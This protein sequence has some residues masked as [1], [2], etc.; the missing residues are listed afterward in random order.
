MQLAVVARGSGSHTQLT[1]ATF[2][3]TQGWISCITRVRTIKDHVLCT[4]DNAQEGEPAS[5][6]CLKIVVKKYLEQKT[7]DRNFDAR[8][9]QIGSGALVKQKICVKSLSGLGQLSAKSPPSL[10]S[11]CQV[12]VG[13]CP[14]LSNLCQVSVTSLSVSVGSLSSLCRCLSVRS[15]SLSVHPSLCQSVSVNLCQSQSVG[16]IACACAPTD[17]PLTRAIL[18]LSHYL[19]FSTIAN[20]SHQDA[21]DDRGRPWMDAKETTTRTASIVKDILLGE[22]DMTLA[23]NLV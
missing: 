12:S 5:H 9:D 18:S 13:L 4:P 2:Q 15:V 7:R 14:S 20:S 23:L 17:S 1:Q 10:S 3:E 22:K 6:T 19:T 11:L 8:N 16:G 21:A